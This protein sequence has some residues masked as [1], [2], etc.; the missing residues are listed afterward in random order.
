MLAFLIYL[1][2][3]VDPLKEVAILIT[4]IFSVGVGITV[5]ISCV[6]CE[7]ID[8]L[9]QHWKI[10]RAFLITIAC[11]LSIAVFTPNAKTIAAMAVIP[12]VVQNEKLQNIAGNSISALEKLT[13]TWLK[14]LA[15]DAKKSLPEKS[16]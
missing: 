15:E 4:S 10:L 6:E 8:A 14:D 1:V 5:I 16:I 7:G 11:T 9:K 3:I 13:E 12:A 2:G